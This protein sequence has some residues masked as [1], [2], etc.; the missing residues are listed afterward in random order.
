[1]VHYILVMVQ[2]NLAQIMKYSINR[3]LFK[4]LRITHIGEM[5]PKVKY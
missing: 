1:M 3:K 2:K 4:V 5:D